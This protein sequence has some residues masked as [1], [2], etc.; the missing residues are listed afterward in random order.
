M[1]GRNGS[2]AGADFSFSGGF[3]GFTEGVECN[4]A[5]AAGEPSD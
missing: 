5:N 1:A 3:A 4:A 2:F